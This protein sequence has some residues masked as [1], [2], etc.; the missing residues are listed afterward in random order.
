[1][2]AQLDHIVGKCRLAREQGYG[3]LSTGEKLAVALVLNRAD[4]LKEMDYTIAEAI[5]RVG[6]DWVTRLRTAERI[7]ADDTP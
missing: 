4:W 2:D 5:D 6:L 1:M 7:L 3:V